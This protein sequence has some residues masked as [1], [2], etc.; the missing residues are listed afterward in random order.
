MKTRQESNT[1]LCWENKKM[2]IPI[3]LCVSN[4]FETTA[5]KL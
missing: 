5:E 4:M 3:D 1:K 2:S